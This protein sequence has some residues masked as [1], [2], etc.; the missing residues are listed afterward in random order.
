MKKFIAY[1]VRLTIIAEKKAKRNYNNS[2][3]YIL[4]FMALLIINSAILG[5]LMLLA[6]RLIP[7]EPDYAR[8][9]LVTPAIAFLFVFPAFLILFYRKRID[10]D[11]LR[12]EV[13][14][15]NDQQLKRKQTIGIFLFML[16]SS[17]ILIVLSVLS[18]LIKFDII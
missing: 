8:E 17:S 7:L 3:L 14:N 18:I 13:N 2:E 12:E 1:F 5:S 9:N 10:I 6:V 11:L 15:F 16:C 4:S